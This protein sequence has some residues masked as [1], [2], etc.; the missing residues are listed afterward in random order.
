MKQ[1]RL[2]VIISFLLVLSHELQSQVARRE[3]YWTLGVQVNAFNYFGDLNPLNRR[4]STEISFT[5]P[6]FAFEVTRK[7]GSRFHLRGSLGYGRLRGDDYVAADPDKPESLGRYGRN[8]HFRSDI[9]ELAFTTIFEIFPSRGRF[10][11]RRYLTP[12]IFAG[13]AGF[14]HNP[15]ARVPIDFASPEGGAA[16]GDWVA[17]KPLRTEGQGQGPG[18][19]KEYSLVQ[20]AVPLGG[21]VRWRINDRMD[22]SFEMGFRILF[23]DHIDDVGGR[24]PDIRDLPSALSRAMFDRSAESIAAA[25][26]GTRDIARISETLGA[27]T[28]LYGTPTDQVD[29]NTL[30]PGENLERLLSYGIRGDKRGNAPGDND[31]YLVTGFRLNYILTTRRY[32]R[33][34]T[35]F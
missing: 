22:L 17:L 35:R 31:M 12:Y 6:N 20:F 24:Y 16:P 30:F 27:L 8:L 11:R 2:L 15:K 7:I 10:Y 4:V 33:L 34:K 13:I 25:A 14:Y 21:G 3:D 26:G 29:I 28:N 23:F 19:G 9:V 32:P 18:Y 1:H 5:R